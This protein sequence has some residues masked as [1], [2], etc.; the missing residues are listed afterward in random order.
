M[1]WKVIRSWL[2][3]SRE[4]SCLAFHLRR[5]DGGE[6]EMCPINYVGGGKLACQK[7]K[8]VN[9]H[10]HVKRRER[11]EPGQLIQFINIHDALIFHCLDLAATS[12]HRLS[13]KVIAS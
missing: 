7:R 2:C 4:A 5:D 9:F 13:T 10:L 12:S 1:Y 6:L 8:E 3:S 11:Q